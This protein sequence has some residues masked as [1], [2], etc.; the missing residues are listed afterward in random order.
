ML[1]YFVAGLASSRS[2]HSQLASGQPTNFTLSKQKHLHKV[3]DRTTKCE[4]TRAHLFL[5][6]A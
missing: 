3:R 4:G 6:T 5:T 1:A 2:C